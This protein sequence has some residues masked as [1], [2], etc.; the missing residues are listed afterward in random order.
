L[1]YWRAEYTIGQYLAASLPRK[2][3]VKRYDYLEGNCT[4]PYITTVFSLTKSLTHAIKKDPTDDVSLHDNTVVKLN[5][6]LGG[7]AGVGLRFST[8]RLMPSQI[9]PS[10]IAPSSTQQ[11]QQ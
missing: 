3:A 2:P 5:S 11:Q 10:H 9:V 4:N 7:V 1:A 8:L 6:L